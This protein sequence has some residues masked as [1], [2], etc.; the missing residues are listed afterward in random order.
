MAKRKKKRGG[1]PSLLQLTLLV[2]LALIVGALAASYANHEAAAWL[3]FGRH[4]GGGAPRIAAPATPI[5][6]AS[7]P[8]PATPAS[9]TP[10]PRPMRSAPPPAWDGLEHGDRVA[11]G[12]PRP[13]TTFQPGGIHLPK[14]RGAA[15]VAIIVDDCGQWID[16]ERGFIALPVPLTLAV[17]PDVRYTKTIAQ[18]AQAAGKGVMLHLPMEPIS[19]INPGPGKITTE[20]G[21]RAIVAQVE[22][23]LAQVPEAAGV[24]NHEGSEATAD[25]RV[26]RDVLGVLK[27]D[28]KFFIDSLTSSKS[29]AGKMAAQDGIPTADRNV[30]LDNEANVAYTE[31]QLR[32]AV[33]VAERDGSAIAIGHPRPS[34]L[35]ALRAMI[36]QMQAAGVQ[37]VLVQDLVH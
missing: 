34:T 9:A 11:L 23:D 2:V 26:M 13:V 4:S 15:R 7:T 18:D 35:E 24:N 30:F 17:L 31:G 10:T 32:E 19:H 37:F 3:P 5:A 25:P 27:R 28:D 33:R 12:V 6:A 29:V 21:N 20:M 8:E 16:T 14:A 1:G 22:R 36:P